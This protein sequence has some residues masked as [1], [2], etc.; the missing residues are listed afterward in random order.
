MLIFLPHR[1]IQCMH[2]MLYHLP[3]SDYEDFANVVVSARTALHL[4]PE[5]TNQFK[6]WLQCIRRFV[7]FSHSIVKCPGWK[8]QLNLC[9]F[10]GRNLVTKIFGQR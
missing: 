3:I 1:Y 6:E 9:V 5:G 8:H 4:T 10:S 7:L 2:Q